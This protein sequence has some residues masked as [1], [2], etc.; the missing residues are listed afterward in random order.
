MK[1]K[2][3][4]DIKNAM[5]WH[6]GSL[7]IKDTLEE[8]N[9]HFETSYTDG[10]SDEEIIDEYGKP[11]EIV[12][13]LRMEIDSIEKKRKMLVI[14]K[15]ILFIICV[16]IILAAFYVFPLNIVLNILAIPSSVFIWYLFGNNCVV[17]ILPRTKDKQHDFV[18][19]QIITLI[20]ILLLHLCSI[21]LIPYIASE[22]YNT[23][24]LKNI[25]LFIYFTVVLLSLIT[26][27]SLK[28]ML[29]GNIDMFI[30][31]IQNISIISGVFLYI[32]FLK[33]IET[34]EKIQFMFTSYFICLP[35]VFLYWIYIYKRQK[36]IKNGCTN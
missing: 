10:L 27:F 11:G 22:G 2:Y 16:F 4:L 32:N 19:G 5:F 12:K 35:V 24:F 15:L 28:K 6:F 30:V 31:I 20:F 14:R 36:G 8:L 13:E 3:L 7:E 18:K 17:G 25:V 29:Q 1:E 23:F 21:V 33:N 9:T 34:I 26:F